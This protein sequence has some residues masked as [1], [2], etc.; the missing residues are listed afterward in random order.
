MG[1]QSLKRRDVDSPQR[2]KFRAR[3][4]R[5]EESQKQKGRRLEETNIHRQ[6]SAGA[7]Q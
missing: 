6:K 1:R 5:E 3:N 4:R 2:G 7:K